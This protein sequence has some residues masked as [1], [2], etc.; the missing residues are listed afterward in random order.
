MSD[1]FTINS[2]SAEQAEEYGQLR[3]IL[4]KFAKTFANTPQRLKKLKQITADNQITSLEITRDFLDLNQNGLTVD[5]FTEKSTPLGVLTSSQKS[6]LS[7][8][9]KNLLD[10]FT[11]HQ[12]NIVDKI[13]DLETYYATKENTSANDD[14]TSSLQQYL[15]APYIF[16]NDAHFIASSIQTA[17]GKDGGRFSTDAY[18]QATHFVR[19]QIENNARFISI[20]PDLIYKIPK[21]QKMEFFLGGDLDL[22]LKILGQDPNI[23]KDLTVSQVS[24]MGLDFSTRDHGWY[25][26]RDV[27]AQ[28]P[29]LV[30]H[31][32]PDLRKEFVAFLHDPSRHPNRG[33]ILYGSEF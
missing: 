28:F 27:Y 2:C 22:A 3:D 11:A 26:L 9:A 8:T 12:V 14:L 20:D 18:L 19:D 24:S 7:A 21:K 29:D 17:L 16:R 33:T 32:N 6:K 23:L 1:S 30:S 4:N 25:W 5:D 31:L 13:I 10:F 15:A